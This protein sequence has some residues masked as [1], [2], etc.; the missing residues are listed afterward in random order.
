MTR[1]KHDQT[2]AHQ[3]EDERYA[4]VPSP[5]FDARYSVRCGVCGFGWRTIELHHAGE[6]VPCPECGAHQLLIQSVALVPKVRP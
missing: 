5:D 2:F 1:R 3:Q 6:L 4:Y